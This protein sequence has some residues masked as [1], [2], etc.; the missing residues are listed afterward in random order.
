MENLMVKKILVVEDEEILNRIYAAELKEEGFDALTAYDGRTAL[1]LLDKENPDLVI[2]DIK[3]PDMNG[4]QVFES[5]RGSR[6]DLPVIICSAYDPVKTGFAGRG[7]AK[8]A[9]LV[10]PVKLDAL[11]EKV[12]Y[13]L[14]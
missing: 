10:K 5:I 9:Y 7:D 13:F 8:A 2:L 3:L 12:R 11:S 6:P 14:G 1:E 4:L